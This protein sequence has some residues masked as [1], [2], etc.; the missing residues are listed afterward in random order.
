MRKRWIRSVLAALLFL[1]LLTG[2]GRTISGM[3]SGKATAPAAVNGAA[4]TAAYKGYAPY[5]EGFY[6][7][8]YSDSGEDYLAPEA[9]EAAPY[10]RA[11]GGMAGSPA[12]DS[13]RAD[14]QDKIIYSGSANVETIRFDETVEQIYN[15]IERHQGFLESA[16]I[17]GRDYNSQYYDRSSYRNAQFVI[18]VPREQ[19]S[20]L[21]S[22]LDTL[23]NVTVSSV[24][25]QN[26]TS[27]YRDT[28]SRL[29]TYR[30]EESR[31]LEM[32][33]K[34]EFVEDMLNIEDRLSNVRYQIESLTT[35]LTNWD[36][37]VNY[38]TMNLT[39]QE[40]KE[41]TVE[42]PIAHTF[43][44]DLRDGIQSS[45]DWLAQA[46]K[47]TVIFLASALPML[48]IPAILILV[49]VLVIR[50]CQRKKRKNKALQ[51]SNDVKVDN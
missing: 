51:R 5:E 30:V 43:G 35:T 50:S 12:G 29:K 27:A 36:S 44:E 26:I 49:I 48:V 2:C 13:N 7:S 1:I 38:S 18:R 42:K 19:F 22:D 20:A 21:R 14:T 45:L 24:E 32:L 11:G 15:M 46:G 33:D 3:S 34:A 40:V 31:L 28:E 6:Y 8:D 4:D 37:K 10:D 41:L 9:M 16:Y 39:V 23:G 47:D 17:T 25:A